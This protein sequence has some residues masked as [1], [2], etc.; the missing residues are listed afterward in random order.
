MKKY[1][2]PEISVTEFEEDDIV[3][4]VMSSG[5][6]YEDGGSLGKSW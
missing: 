4:T 2:K 1:V 5:Q 3:L 6:D